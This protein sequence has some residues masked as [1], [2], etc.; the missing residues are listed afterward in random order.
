MFTEVLQ[1]QRHKDDTLQ[2]TGNRSIGRDS[3]GTAPSHEN[4]SKSGFP[5]WEET[6]RKTKDFVARKKN[7][8]MVRNLGKNP[9]MESLHWGWP[10][11]GS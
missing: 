2:A 6:A 3:V 11:V 9:A 1:T 5:Q 10:G 4:T 7:S 8:P